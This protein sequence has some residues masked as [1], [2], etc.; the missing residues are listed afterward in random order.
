ME[1]IWCYGQRSARLESALENVSRPW[2]P[3]VNSADRLSALR[4]IERACARTVR[5]ALCFMVGMIGVAAAAQAAP[6]NCPQHLLDA[7]LAEHIPNGYASRVPSPYCDGVVRVQFDSALVFVSLVEGDP[8]PDSQGPTLRA[9][10]PAPAVPVLVRGA[11]MDAH[12]EWRLDGVIPGS[13]LSVDR[14]P[15]LDH[16]GLANKRL[17]FLA[18]YQSSVGTVYLPVRIGAGTDHA[19]TMIVRTSVDFAVLRYQLKVAGSDAGPWIPAKTQIPH[20]SLVRIRLPL[21]DKPHRLIVKVSAETG[22]PDD[23][24]TLPVVLIDMPADT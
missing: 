9:A 20:G 14:G 23:T 6:L 13:G 11:D 18:W 5:Q 8:P 22:S 1:V 24:Q 15:A 10:A 3:Y 19:V 2:G 16:I 17:G 12:G 7:A 21:T 4:R